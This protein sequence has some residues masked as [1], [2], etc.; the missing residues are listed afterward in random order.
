[1]MQQTEPKESLAEAVR[2]ANA[3]SHIIFRRA[4]LAFAVVLCVFCVWLAL[5]ELSRSGIDRLP[6]GPASAALAA[7]R[8]GAASRAA[9]IGMIRGDLWA[10]SA[11]T[12]AN[13]LWSDGGANAGATKALQHAHA[14]LDRALDDAPHQSGAWL[15]LAALAA[16]YPASNSNVTEALKMSYYTGPSEQDLMALRL[17]V[18][19][20][21][22]AFTD[23]DIR[24]FIARDLR[25]FLARNQAGSITAAYNSASPA[26]KQFIEQ[27]V[28]AIDPAALNSIRA[29]RSKQQ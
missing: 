10:E 4:T 23:S 19:M 20:N 22:G 29:S 5:P 24:E 14:S 2:P 3:P 7:S 26:G 15:L 6:T 11:F 1:M 12:Y 16:R 27:T 13:L 17:S 18:A 28:S 8:R 21:S 9:W 25:L